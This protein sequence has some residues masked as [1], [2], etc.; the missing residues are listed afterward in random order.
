M[1][2]IFFPEKQITRCSDVEQTIW[3]MMEEGEGLYSYYTKWRSKTENE[4]QGF[5][6][7]L[8]TVALIEVMVTLATL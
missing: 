3:E 4:L 1:L 2:V 6:W 5:F 8:F 7:F